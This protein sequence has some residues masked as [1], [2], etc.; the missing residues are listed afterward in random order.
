[1]LYFGCIVNAYIWFLRIYCIYAF[2]VP[3]LA[4]STKLNW[5]ELTILTVC[6]DTHEMVNNKQFCMYH[7]LCKRIIHPYAWVNQPSVC[8]CVFQWGQFLE[9]PD[10][11]HSCSLRWIRSRSEGN[12]SMIEGHYTVWKYVKIYNE[13]HTSELWF[14]AL[15]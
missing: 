12:L 3:T 15:W 13:N 1:M 11:Y 6:Y 8:L 9:I 4:S 14:K 10:V 7:A 5:I 2:S